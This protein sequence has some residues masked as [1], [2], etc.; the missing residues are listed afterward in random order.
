MQIADLG[1]LFFIQMF[2]IL[3]CC[4]L[5]GWGLNKYLG[6]PQVIGEMI[7]GVLLGPSLFGL[8]LPDLQA[9]LFPTES[10]PILYV[11]SQFGIGLFMFIVGMGFHTD[12]F[13]SNTK[14]AFTISLSGIIAPFIIAFAITPLLFKVPG[15]FS[16]N[17]TLYQA[18]L[19]LGAC[20]AITAFPVLARIIHEKKLQNTRIGTL[21][22]SSAAIDDAGAWCVVALV[23]AT[24]GEGAGVAIKAVAGGAAF[25]AFMILVGPKIMAPLAK[26]VEREGQMTPLVLSFMLMLFM[27][28]AYAMD[29]AGL[30]AVFGGF[31]LGT[32]VPRGKLTEE[33]KRALEPFAILVLVPIFFTYSGLH[34]QLNVIG[35]PQMMLIAMG[36]LVA[37]VLAKGGACYLAARLTGEDN[38]TA[39]SVGT[40]M[41]AR[42]L[43]ELI[44]INIGLQKGIIQPGLFTVL[45]IMAIV[46]T[47]MTSPVF[48][49][50]NRKRIPI[51]DAVETNV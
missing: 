32:V 49:L 2:V 47:L 6:Q 18:S 1:V 7:A 31:I 26:I 29:V 3:A 43:T 9:A 20:I 37:C 21:T 38:K 10:R 51:K 4:R 19:F 40:L 5:I 35:S 48:D 17:I 50:I 28:S 25:V 46:T 42:G 24:M 34:T 44:I 27:L 22:L 30:H 41:N 33:L 23:L 16:E 11:I 14:S 8:L 13:K 45:V 12:H 15:L 36:V 39:L